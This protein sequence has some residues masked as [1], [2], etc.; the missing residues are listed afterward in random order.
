MPNKWSAPKCR[1]NYAGEQPTPVFKMPNGTPEIVALWKAFLHREH[2]EDIKKIYVC[3]K[4]S[5]FSIPQQDGTRLEV[6]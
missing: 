3:L 4:Q 5:H 1:S 6:S 2:I